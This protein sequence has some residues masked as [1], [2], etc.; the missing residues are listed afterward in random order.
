MTQAKDHMPKMLP[1]PCIHK[2]IAQNGRKKK[3]NSLA[4]KIKYAQWPPHQFKTELLYNINLVWEYNHIKRF[5]VIL[6]T[7]AKQKATTKKR[8]S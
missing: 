8:L 5:S 7:K 6:F 1:L 4:A 3:E 2:K